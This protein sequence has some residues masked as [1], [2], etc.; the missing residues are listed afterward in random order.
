MS[1][2]CQTPRVIPVAMMSGG[3]EGAGRSVGLTCPKLQTAVS[4]GPVR[5]RQEVVAVIAGDG[6]E[7][8]LDVG[9][10]GDRTRGAEPQRRGELIGAGP[11]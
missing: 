6:P 7:I 8:D 4:V 2:R 1:R 9:A 3:K 5:Q 10:I 11:G